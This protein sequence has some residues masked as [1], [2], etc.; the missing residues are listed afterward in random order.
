VA[1]PA[2]RWREGQVV[3]RREVWRGRPWAAIPVLVVRD[4]PD[5]LATYIAEG[6]ELGFAGSDDW[7]GGPHPWSGKS[8]WRGHGALTLQRP[9]DAYGI[10]VFWR[11]PGRTFAG[12]YV[13]FQAPFQRTASGYDTLD[14]ELDIWI[15]AGGDGW[16]WK[17]RD[18]LQQSVSDGRF[19]QAEVDEILADGERV[20][21]ELDS[22]RRWWDDGWRDWEPDPEWAPPRL[23]AAWEAA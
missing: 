11:R 20:A 16:Q 15:P 18:R 4:E 5:L 3:V 23:P 6:A 14:H 2:A 19:T 9:R 22:G 21:A 8:A 1:E 10:F 12:W 17:D 13:N 7:P